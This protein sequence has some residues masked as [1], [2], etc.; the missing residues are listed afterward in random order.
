MEARLCLECGEPLRGRADQKFCNDMCRNAY[1]NK[2]QGRTT[3]Y[4]RKIN[5]ILKTNH[6]ILKDLNTDDKT[7]VYSKKLQKQNFNF[8]YY[9]HT[10]TTRNGSVYHFCYDQGYL[11]LG[12]NRYLLVKKEDI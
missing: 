11:K 7:T 8:N 4:M 9:T 6:S 1:N 2:K 3:K 12:N 5:R 10:Y